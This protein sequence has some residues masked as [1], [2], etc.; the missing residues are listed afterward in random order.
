MRREASPLRCS[1]RRALLPRSAKDS[2]L[3][4]PPE[5]RPE[6]RYASLSRH[7]N[8]GAE[9]EAVRRRDK[10][11]KERLVAGRNR[12]RP[13]Q[14]LRASQPGR[15]SEEGRKNSSQGHF[16]HAHCPELDRRPPD[17]RSRFCLGPRGSAAA[18][19]AHA[20]PASPSLAP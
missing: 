3:Q 20:A 5:A 7:V 11:G 1:Q 10:L 6:T 18:P 4:T 12:I 2:C 14:E 17:P 8:L 9:S 19:E 13:A 16:Q 15:A